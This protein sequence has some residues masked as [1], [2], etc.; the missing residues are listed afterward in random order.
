MQ[1]E[2]ATTENRIAFARQFFNDAV[3]DYNNRMR[4][5]PGNL[6]AGPFGFR[7]EVFFEAPAEA[8]KKPVVQF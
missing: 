2:I 8:R 1:E 3:L 7:E 5:L 6:V 4:T